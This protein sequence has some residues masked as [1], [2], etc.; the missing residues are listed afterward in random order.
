MTRRRV[1][2]GNP[3]G[4]LLRAD[5]PFELHKGLTEPGAM[6][7]PEAF[8]L[9]LADWSQ[10]QATG[11]VSASVI[12][13]YTHHCK[14]LLRTVQRAGCAVVGDIT[15]NHIWLWL[16]APGP[17]DPNATPTERTMSARRA[18]ARMFFHTAFRL[19]ITDANPAMSVDLGSVS[20][21]YVR[22]LTDDQ[23]RV[24]KQ[25]AYFRIGETRV[26]TALALC[27]SGATAREISHLTVDD[28][29][30]TCGRVWIHDGGYR[31]RDRWVPL[32]DA[33]CAEAVAKRVRELRDTYGD[34]A[35]SVWLIYKPHPSQPTPKRQDTAVTQR[36]T[37]LLKKARVYQA[38]VTRVE[39]IREWTA[40]QIYASTGRVEE[41]AC[42]L[43]MSSLDAAAHL[44]GH[45][46]TQEFGIVDEPPA[47]RR[48]HQS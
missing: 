8:D 45:E 47:H 34:D 41:V 18:S 1:G 22:P 42:R 13:F 17:R 38:G 36:M 39:S 19:G 26:P 12:A 11:A 6:P 29:D 9:V 20:E 16:Q 10:Q 43:G 3:R 31:Q 48:D 14:G 33:W 27:L 23:I 7:L 40:A 15:A 5:G 35:G 24:L 32:F 30:L 25:T 46:W 4:Q 2:D 28:V 21:R 44:V 37:E